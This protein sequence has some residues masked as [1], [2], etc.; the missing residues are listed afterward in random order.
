M[1][2]LIGGLA[3]TMPYC[4]SSTIWTPCSSWPGADR[5]GERQNSRLRHARAI[6]ANREVQSAYLGGQRRIL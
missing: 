6:R 5:H 4:W 1:V 2:A 3:E